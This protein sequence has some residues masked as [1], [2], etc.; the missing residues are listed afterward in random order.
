L[1]TTTKS[2]LHLSLLD[3]DPDPRPNIEGKRAR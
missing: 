3:I 2:I 1:T